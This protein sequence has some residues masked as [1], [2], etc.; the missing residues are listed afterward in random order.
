MKWEWGGE[1]RFEARG[2]DEV[3]KWGDGK[4][5]KREGGI[6]KG[7]EVLNHYCDVELPVKERREWAMGALGGMCVCER[8]V[9]EEGEELRKRKEGGVEEGG[10]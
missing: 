5:K 1:I 7:E 9:W 10:E 6:K 8:C 3:V 4:G 2:G